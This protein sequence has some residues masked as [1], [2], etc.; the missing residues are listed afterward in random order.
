MKYDVSVTRVRAES[1]IITVDAEDE[2]DAREKALDI[3]GPYGS[4]VDFEEKED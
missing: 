2:D 1:V 3:A 4:C